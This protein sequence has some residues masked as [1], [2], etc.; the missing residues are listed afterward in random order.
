V[1]ESQQNSGEASSSFLS[2]LRNAKEKNAMLEKIF[3]V[4]E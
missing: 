2:L 4:Q 1:Q 3:L